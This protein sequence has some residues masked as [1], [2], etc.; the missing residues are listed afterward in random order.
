MRPVDTIFNSRWINKY[1]KPRCEKKYLII[2]LDSDD[3]RQI[4]SSLKTS[5][6]SELDPTNRYYSA[7]YYVNTLFTNSLYQHGESSHILYFYRI[8]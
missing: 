7:P 2:N 5:E 8:P 1:T 3:R 4:F 6:S